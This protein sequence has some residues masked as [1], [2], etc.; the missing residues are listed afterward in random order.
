MLLIAWRLPAATALAAS[1]ML[2][3]CGTSNDGDRQAAAV[4]E[5]AP[6]AIVS[7]PPSSESIQMSVGQLGEFVAFP[8]DTDYVIESSA[9]EVVD[10]FD[11][12]TDDTGVSI[13]GPGVVA[14]SVGTADIVVYDPE[15]V[16]DPFERF[17]ILVTEA[18]ELSEDA[19]GDD[20]EGAIVASGTLGSR[21]CVENATTQSA[22]QEYTKVTF[23][24][25]DSAENGYV[26]PGRPLCAEGT[27]RRP[28]S[29]DLRG[30]LSFRD[31]PMMTVWAQNPWAGLPGAGSDFLP[32]KAPDAAGL[33]FCVGGQRFDVGDSLSGDNGVYRLVVTRL[34]DT[35][36]KEFTIRIEDSQKPT[37]DG[38]FRNCS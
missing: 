30:E 35:K 26:R 37:P 36:W 20:I 17:R 23:T 28:F 11:G 7:L 3:G 12:Y 14:L 32:G 25:A 27:D 19:S 34:P 10:V 1:V 9:P 24:K 5:A 38:S 22:D 33:G 21:I 2:A 16:G 15:L 29:Y 4:I 13:A 31:V 6:I 18:P 8:D